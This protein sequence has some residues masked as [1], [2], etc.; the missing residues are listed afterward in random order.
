MTN[1]SIRLSDALYAYLLWVSSREP[2]VLRRLR[3]AM[4]GMI[5]LADRLTLARKR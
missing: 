1:K 3:A 2:E 5:P 4:G